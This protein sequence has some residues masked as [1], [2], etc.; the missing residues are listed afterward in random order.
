MRRAMLLMLM[1]SGTV[2]A[3]GE[4]P[5][6]DNWP[7]A[8]ID[9]GCTPPK[10]EYYRPLPPLPEIPKVSAVTGPPT[11]MLLGVAMLLAMWWAMWVRED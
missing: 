1:L 3:D 4:D 9:H 7:L 10:L 6:F 5:G 2:H 8:M 11:L